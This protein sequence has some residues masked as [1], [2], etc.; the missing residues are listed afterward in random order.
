MNSSKSIFGLRS[1]KSESP[2]HQTLFCK[3][4]TNKI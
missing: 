4:Q 2:M 1:S 3:Q